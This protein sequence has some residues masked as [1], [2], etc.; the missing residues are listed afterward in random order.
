MADFY[1]LDAGEVFKELLTSEKG[2][3]SQDAEKRLAE[4]G[5]NE[6][7]ERKKIPAWKVFLAQ[8]KSALIYVLIAAGVIN[9]AIGE[10]D[11]AILVGVIV[12]INAVIGFHQ[13]SK[14]EKALD[15]L[16]KI[17][18]SKARVLRN[19]KLELID[20]K[21]L[22]PG[23]VIFV[24][25][26]DIVPADARVFESVNLYANEAVLTGE[27]LPVGKIVEKILLEKAL[28]AEQKNMIFSGTIIAKGRGKAVVIATGQKTEFGKIAEL[29]QAT[30]ET[31]TPLAEKMDRLGGF[32]AKMFVVITIG[33]FAL[34]IFSGTPAL[35][36]LLI[37]IS[38][39]V[40]AIPEG[41]P[42]IVTIALAFGTQTMAKNNAIVRKLSA[43]E[44]LGS[45]TV[46]CSDKTGTITKNELVVQKVFVPGQEFEVTGEGYD[47]EGEISKES[48]KSREFSALAKIAVLCNNAQIGKT[49]KEII[50]DPT[51]IALLVLGKKSGAEKEIFREEFLAELEFDSE[52]KMMSVLYST[53]KGNF[54]YAKGSAESILAKCTKYLE[55]GAEKKLTENKLHEFL[56]KNSEL[57]E[58][59]LRVLG[60]AFK[61]HGFG[62][63]KLTDEKDLIF[64]GLTGMI[65]A[66]H[67]ESLE[68]IAL[69]KKAGIQVKMIT[70]D[71]LLTAVAIA[72]QV[73][74]LESDEE[75]DGKII[76]GQELDKMSD[77][78]LEE[79]VQGIVVFA[80]AS[81]QHKVRILQA[82][83]KKGNVVAMTGDGINDAPALK[84]ADIGI[85]MGLTGTD[86]AK[87]AADMIILDDNF[88]TIVKAVREGRKIY[89]NI[90]GSVMFLLSANFAEVLLIGF[91]TLLSSIFGLGW[92]VPLGFMQ[93]LWVNI[94][95]DLFPALALSREEISEKVMQEKPLNPKENLLSGIFP[96][97]VLTAV[98]GSLTVLL[99][100]W[101]GLQEGG[102][103]LA[104]TMALTTLIFFELFFVF[105]CRGNG[106]TFFNKPFYENKWLLGAVL[107]S[108][109]LHLILLNVE[110]LRE[111]F[112]LTVMSTGNLGIVIALSLTALAVPYLDRAIK[113]LKR[114]TLNK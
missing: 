50:G 109:G 54:L 78:E 33:I 81:P 48:E 94:A 22:I 71:H 103:I 113:H 60:F 111:I 96:Y 53:E 37:A 8:F 56:D 70:G 9:F 44:T 40:A 21:F 98:V 46:I 83:Q 29:L 107:L 62:K 59:G 7:L 16:K 14:A 34:G 41:L 92:P 57:A 114:I 5:L 13:E 110:F 3:N 25:H 101:I 19:G 15:A 105:N 51:E 39:A 85:A 4:F 75:T 108:I 87:Q 47:F 38:L 93:I 43:V 24:E 58:K 30:E 76:E 88:S 73:C 90:K 104:K 95:T 18:V 17:A 42:A 52:R 49:Q 45:T 82:L 112:G 35:E 97:V 84:N 72:K 102:K 80:R 74:L 10:I 32:L 68:A 1:K 89:S 91:A 106:V 63:L 20:S 100:F 27:S 23:D 79:K 28:P 67:K 64:V 2:L 69:C 36:M 26:G 61:E 6:L 31:K 65:D 55:N 77:K 66:P 12:L 86:V 11:G 99:A